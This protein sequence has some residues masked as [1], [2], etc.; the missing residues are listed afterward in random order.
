MKKLVCFILLLVIQQHTSITQT[1]LDGTYSL[2]SNENQ[3]AEEEYVFSD[4]SLFK[5]KQLK[6]LANECGTGEFI[7][8]DSLLTLT[9]HEVP[10][11][12][13][14]SL[15]SYY[16][17]ED[18]K[19]S[20][21]DT[22]E[23]LI[24]IYD[25]NDMPLPGTSAQ[26]IDKEGY[27]ITNKVKKDWVV[28]SSG[29]VNVSFPSKLNFFGIKIAFMGYETLVIPVKK[30]TNEVITVKMLEAEKCSRVYE[31]GTVKKYYL[32]NVRHSGFYMREEDSDDYKY[33]KKE[34]F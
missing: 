5:F 30:D 1:E 23:Y 20:K 34:K 10:K 26:L 21:G 4:D 15:R 32:K 11:T 8:T 29:E 13:K 27:N 24:R 16:I 7:I 28:D 33:Y 31:A 12:V 2:Y 25:H 19:L 17:I 14:D 6:Y 22:A 18:S 3:N 9:F